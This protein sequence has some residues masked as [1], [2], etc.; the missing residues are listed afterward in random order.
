MII[1]HKYIFPPFS[2]VCH[3]WLLFKSLNTC[4]IQK[5][6]RNMQNYKSYLNYYQWY[7][8]N[9]NKINDSSLNFLNKTKDESLKKSQPRQTFENGGSNS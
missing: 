3:G 7:K 4:L 2:N 9:P 8:A 5:I 1:I 6:Y